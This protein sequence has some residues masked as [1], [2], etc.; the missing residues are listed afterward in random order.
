MKMK[1]TSATYIGSYTQ[2][3]ECPRQ[4]LPEFAFIG[5][6]NVGKSSLIN[7]LCNRK[8]LAKTSQTPGKTKMLNFFLINEKWRLIDMPGYG[9]ARL[10]KTEIMRIRKMIKNFLLE[11]TFLVCVM[12]L[13]DSRIPP[14]KSDLEFAAWLGAN[15]IPFVI[16][17][18]KTDKANNSCI[19]QFKNEMLQSWESL[20]QI[21]MTSSEKRTGA[22]ALLSFIEQTL[23]QCAAASAKNSGK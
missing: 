2:T 7:Y 3:D 19:E 4:P 9:Y 8:N 20:P 10:P 22:E 16:V 13:I 18:T 6:S 17:F 23:Q 21:F 1:I 5:R 12:L 11:R 15:E 14:Q